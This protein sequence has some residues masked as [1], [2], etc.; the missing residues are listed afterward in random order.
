MK[1]NVKV[2]VKIPRQQVSVEFASLRAWTLEAIATRWGVP[3]LIM[4]EASTRYSSY[5]RYTVLKRE[6]TS[7]ALVPLTANY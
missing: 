4:D 2:N 3:R 6:S 1:D 5:R 7:R